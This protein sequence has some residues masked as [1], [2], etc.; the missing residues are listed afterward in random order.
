[1][2]AQGEYIATVKAECRNQISD[3]EIRKILSAISGVQ[4]ISGRN[5][6]FEFR[7]TREVFRSVKAALKQWCLVQRERLLHDEGGG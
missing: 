4:I 3:H 5:G 7:C 1:M 6:I 2:P